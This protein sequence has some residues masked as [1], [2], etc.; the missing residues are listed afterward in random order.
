MLIMSYFV[1]IIYSE[2]FDAFYKGQT[3]NLAQRLERHNKGLEKSTAR[4]KPWVLI[5][6]TE[7]ETRR[8]SMALEKKL[9]NLSRERLSSFIKKYPWKP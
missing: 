1:Y 5:W 7:K 8:D 2:K 3:K 4:Y 6:A 9:K